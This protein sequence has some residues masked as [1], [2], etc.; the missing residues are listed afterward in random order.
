MARRTDHSAKKSKGPRAAA[1]RPERPPVVAATRAYEQWLR[2]RVDVVESDLNFKH[3][4]MAQSLFSFLLATFY[5]WVP[6][7]QQVC[8]SLADAPRVLA[9]GDLHVENFG[10]WRDEEGRL[11]WGVNDFDE[12]APMPYTVDLVR[13]VASAI[14]AERENKLTL[15]AASTATAV[16]EGYAKSLEVRGVPFVLEE[17]HPVLREMALVAEREPTRF[18]A[19]LQ[20]LPPKTPSKSIRR[21]LRRSLP[22]GAD[23]RQ[24][25]HRRAGLGSLGRPRFVAIAH[26]H[27]GLVAR[28]AKAWL[29]SAWGWANGCQEERAYALPLLA[30]SIRQPDPY[31]GVEDGWV[32]RRL[33]PHCG[34][35]ELAQLP[36]K[37]DER[38]ILRAMGGEIANLH[39][40]TPAQ[41][42][43][44]LRDL[45]KRKPG[46]LVE[47]AQ[48]MTDVT[49]RDW[50]AY[51]AAHRRRT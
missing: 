35:I 43:S 33:G 31:Y 47:A 39:L 46:W 12:A 19:K 17:N 51:R 16:L 26:C 13:L 32:I 29:P 23:G 22:E 18:W 28:E 10:T 15:D 2:S 24:Y 1:N 11:I 14:I 37:R 3:D 50:R 42:K 49:T 36:K 21:L 6:L 45:A 8:A 44:V 7:W 20:A 40:A 4:S 34:R 25:M 48:A 38:R 27:G 30:R 41:R 9:V 5:R